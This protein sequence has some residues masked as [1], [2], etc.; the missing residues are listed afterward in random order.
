MLSDTFNVF[1]VKFKQYYVENKT[2][3]WEKEFLFRA[4]ADR[5]SNNWS[6]D[7]TTGVLIVTEKDERKEMQDLLTVNIPNG[8]QCDE[9][10]LLEWITYS[11][12]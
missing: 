8:Y 11:K 3:R 7:C 5:P 4:P 1:C 2:A 9:D 10:D 6:I 12:T